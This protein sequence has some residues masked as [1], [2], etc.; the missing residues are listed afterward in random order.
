MIMTAINLMTQASPVLS[1]PGAGVAAVRSAGGVQQSTPVVA[2][3]VTE[4]TA[5]QQPSLQDVQNAV[6][7]A[8]VALQ[9]SNEAITFGY[10]EKLG[11][12]VVQVSDKSTGAVIQ[13]LP[14]KDFIQFQLHMRE[15][16]GLFLDKKA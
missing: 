3:Q 12:L 1:S 16:V 6:K 5:D 10:E 14:S 13:Q 11:Q 15:M 2:K 7:Q 9:G 4:S 8:N